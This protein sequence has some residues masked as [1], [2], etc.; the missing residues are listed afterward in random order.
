MMGS[1]KV[2]EL[3]LKERH[4]EESSYMY[5]DATEKSGSVVLGRFVPFLMRSNN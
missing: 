3:S 2:H 4:V 1:I 5:D